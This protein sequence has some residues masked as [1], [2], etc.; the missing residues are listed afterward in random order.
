MRHDGRAHRRNLP[1]RPSDRRGRREGDSSAWASRQ[2]RR[3]CPT[4]RRAWRQRASAS[5]LPSGTLVMPA[6]CGAAVGVE[7]V[8]DGERQVGWFRAAARRRTQHSASP[9]APVS[10]R[11]QRPQ[12]CEAT[13]ADDALRLLADRAEDA[14]HAAA[15]VAQRAVRERVVRLLQEATP[16]EQ[17]QQ[18]AIPGRRALLR[19]RF[20]MRPRCR[21]R[22]P[23][24]P[25]ASACRAPRMLGAQGRR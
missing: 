12:R 10:S 2:T 4:R 8:D 22:S 25:R 9:S 16:V 23:D 21:P 24:R 15:I 14:L 3:R 5:S 20:R 18:R 7:Q 6:T 11:G 19:R 17:Q 1:A 13:L